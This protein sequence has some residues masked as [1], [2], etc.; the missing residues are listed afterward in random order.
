MKST[1]V[2]FF[3]MSVDV[4]IAQLNCLHPVVSIQSAEENEFN[5]FV[6]RFK[7]AGK[8]NSTEIKTIPVVVHVIYRNVGDSIMMS[9]SR[10]QSQIKATN[11]QLRRK[12]ADTFKT[13]TQFKPIAADINIEVCLATKLPNGNI[14]SGVIY[15]KLPNYIP[16]SL[17]DVMPRTMLNPERYLNVWVTPDAEGGAAT[18]PWER[19]SQRDGFWVGAKWFGIEGSNLAPYTN[20][21]TT[22]THELAHYLGVYHV[23]HNSSVY[24]GQCELKSTDTLGDYC[25]DTPL[26][27]DN[28]LSIEQCNDGLRFCLSGTDSF[29]SQTEN[30][31]YYNVDSCTNMFSRDQR[32]RMRACL[33]SLRATLVSPSNL[34][35]TGACQTTKP[36]SKYYLIKFQGDLK[37]RPWQDSVFIVKVSNPIVQQQFSAEIAKPWQQ[38][39]RI[40]N[41]RLANGNGD[42]NRNASR[43]FNWQMIDSTVEL[44]ELANE[45]CDGRPYSDVELG[46]FVSNPGAYCPWS[47]RVWSETLPIACSSSAIRQ[48]DVSPLVYVYPIPSENI[49]YIKDLPKSSSPY[50]YRVTNMDGKQFDFGSFSSYT[51]NSIDIKY[52]PKGIYLLNLTNNNFNQIYKFIKH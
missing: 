21:G 17:V 19:T 24:L 14:F 7:L 5:D 31:M 43:C 2:L 4:T 51:L 23:H 35:A 28:P 41:A 9:N 36:S 25:G 52:L 30:Y 33:D 42:Y 44:V 40:V 20:E 18:F 3:L 48:S 46:N 34:L 26:D 16:D 8:Q 32:T 13:R 47:M 12:N 1:F 29:W 10:I 6:K 22:F 49:L 50:S 38:R 45:T 39:S 11:I 37:G 15:H 27:W